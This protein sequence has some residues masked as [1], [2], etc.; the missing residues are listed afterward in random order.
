M[1]KKIYR[2]DDDISFRKCSLFNEKDTR[3]T[4]HTGHGD[5][6]SFCT[7]TINY[8]DYYCCTQEG[9]HL[10]CTKHP[11][12][13]LEY[14]AE[15]GLYCQKCNKYIDISNIKDIINRC[16]RVLNRE[17]F[18]NAKFIRTDDWYTPE[19]RKKTTSVPNYSIIRLQCIHLIPLFQSIFI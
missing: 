1:C 12:I 9:I 16:L 11:E 6:T 13:E 3:D 19:T 2:L 18:R 5:C 15:Y 10:H 4:T 17:V 8:Q 14:V 7:R